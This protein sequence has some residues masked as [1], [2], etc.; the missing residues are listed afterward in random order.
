MTTHSILLLVLYVTSLV[1]DPLSADWFCRNDLE[2]QCSDTSCEATDRQEFTT[3]HLS[4]KANGEFMVCAYTGCWEGIGQV[5]ETRPFLIIWKEQADWYTQ[6]RLG[7]NAQNVLIAFDRS[8]KVASL[9]VGGWAH[10]MNCSS[11]P[12]Q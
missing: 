6:N 8:D 3:M 7:T 10:P 2:I 5:I 11:E 12:S 4:F 1:D 9:K